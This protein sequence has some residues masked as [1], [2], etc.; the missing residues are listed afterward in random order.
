M[1]PFVGVDPIVI[2]QIALPASHFAERYKIEFTEEMDDLGELLIAFI[3]F[4]SGRQ[5]CLVSRHLHPYLCDKVE[6]LVP[7]GKANLWRTLGEFIETFSI[8]ED[9]VS[10]ISPYVLKIPRW[11]LCQANEFG[12]RRAIT[13]TSEQAH[14]LRISVSFSSRGGKGTYSCHELKPPNP[15]DC[16]PD[17]GSPKRWIWVLAM[18]CS[19]AS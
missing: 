19:F 14:A 12:V 11:V 16:M 15:E 5:V 1:N 10:W 4:A 18:K 8:E 9:S 6:V 7:P 3:T 13:A 2:A 17:T